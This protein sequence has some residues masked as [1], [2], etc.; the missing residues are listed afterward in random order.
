MTFYV[1]LKIL[2]MLK[3]GSTRWNGGICRLVSFPCSSPCTCILKSDSKKSLGR[4]ISTCQHRLSAISSWGSRRYRLSGRRFIG[5]NWVWW[6]WFTCFR[7]I[8]G[9]IIRLL[10]AISSSFLKDLILISAVI[11]KVLQNYIIFVSK[12]YKFAIFHASYLIYFII[13]L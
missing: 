8:F 5:W 10:E 4:I 12:I 13:S 3:V 11:L 1:I 2:S 6:I 7:W 9:V